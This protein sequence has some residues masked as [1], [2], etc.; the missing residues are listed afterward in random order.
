METKIGTIVS[1]ND[2]KGFASDEGFERRSNGTPGGKLGIGSSREFSF[3][4]T[5]SGHR[6]HGDRQPAR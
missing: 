3:Q 4:K 2:L 1:G 6:R 5:A